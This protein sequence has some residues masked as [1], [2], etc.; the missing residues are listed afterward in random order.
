MKNYDEISVKK[1]PFSIYISY[2]QWREQTGWVHSP[3]SSLEGSF[4]KTGDSGESGMEEGHVV[5]DRD[6][7][8]PLLLSPFK[9]MSQWS[10]IEELVDPAQW[11][12]KDCLVAGPYFS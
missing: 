10:D 6:T 1:H 7:I 12:N 8:L 5:E 4:W 3:L 11:D 2:L 9:R